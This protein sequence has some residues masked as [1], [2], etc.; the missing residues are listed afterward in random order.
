MQ[1]IVVVGA[2]LA[3]LR[4]AEMLRREG[5]SGE[6]HIVGEEPHLPYDRPPLSKQVLTGVWER[7]RVNLVD[8]DARRLLDATWHLDT[9]AIALD[10]D[11][12]QVRLERDSMLEY[13]GLIIATGARPRRLPGTGG[14]G[15]VHALR[16]IDDATA[17]RADIDAGARTAV[18]VGAGFIGAEVTASLRTLGLDV[19]MV[20]ALPAPFER[21]L[22]VEMGSVI[23]DAH[24][25]QG[26]DVRVGVGVE[27]LVGSERVEQ[28]VLA[29]GTALATD[30]VVVGVGVI[31]NTEWLE[32]SGLTL[33][34]GVVC[35][36]TCLAAPGV[37]AAGDVA[38]W[39]NRRFGE[40][41]RVEHW[42][43]AV[44]QGGHAARRLLAGDDADLDEFA[45]EPIPWFWTDQYAMKIQLAGRSGPDQR[46]AV[47]SGSVEERKFAAIYGRGDRLVAVLGFNRP[48][49]VM[50]YRQLIAEGASF[51]D[52]LTFAAE[53]A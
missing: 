8:D 25:E 34:N 16:T 29:D 7:D 33:D 22:G 27:E 28:V 52:A 13:D 23:I 42:D 11:A 3:G 20:E 45:Y 2:S 30:L 12:R 49:Q 32:G 9:R 50:Q 48:R 21:V 10:L 19:A 1:R 15:G 36:E 5:Y 14:L 6:L 53:S 38:R 4:A 40:V 47:V 51:D 35:D 24:R 46:I 44:D 26:V 31:P 43:N 41:M 17:L 18:V 37:V 39:P